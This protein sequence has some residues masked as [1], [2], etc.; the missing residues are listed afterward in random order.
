MILMLVDEDENE[1]EDEDEDEEGRD[2]DL[3]R[4]N[5]PV[6]QPAAGHHLSIQIARVK[7]E[8]CRVKSEEPPC[9]EIY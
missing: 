8:E 9:W 7:S 6:Q 5:D 4:A 1:D 2:S 3:G